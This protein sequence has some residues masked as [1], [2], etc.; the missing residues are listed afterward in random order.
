MHIGEVCSIIEAVLVLNALTKRTW[1]T[2]EFTRAVI[3]LRLPVYA[4]APLS[5]AI[6][7]KRYVDDRLVVTLEP[8]M[9]AHYVTLLQSEIEE[10]AYSHWPQI[11]T[12]RPA[13][14]W[15]DKP[16]RTWDEIAVFRKGDHRVLGHWET[17]QGEWMG[18]SDEYFFSEPVQVTAQSTLVVPRHTIAELVRNEAVTDMQ[19][20]AV[21]RA[22]PLTSLVLAEDGQEAMEG[23]PATNPASSIISLASVAKATSPVA[24]STQ[25]GATATPQAKKTNT[26]DQHDLRRLLEESLIQGNTHAVLAKKYGVSR[27]FIGKQI[28]TAKG[29]FSARKPSPFDVLG[30]RS[31]KK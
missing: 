10:L 7:C 16:Y 6:V 30:S 12:D 28:A 15:G 20:A 14:L 18:Q 8:S 4:A 22:D 26:W 9:N 23:I 21:D 5:T 11:I 2:T 31:R 27:Q 1:T 3:R 29:L 13:W 24:L 25:G 17:D 19:M